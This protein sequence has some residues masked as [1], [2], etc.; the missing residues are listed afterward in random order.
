[1]NPGEVYSVGVETG[2]VLIASRKA[3]KAAEHM[4]VG[5]VYDLPK[6]GK[7]DKDILG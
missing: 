2:E 6:P 3:I 5:K 4:V 1:M 7:A